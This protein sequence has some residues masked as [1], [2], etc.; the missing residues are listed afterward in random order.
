MSDKSIVTLCSE[1]L[2]WSVSCGSNWSKRISVKGY[3]LGNSPLF[4]F[5][6]VLTCAAMN[7]PDL[8]IGFH[9]LP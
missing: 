7:V 9:D 2:F 1:I 4:Y 5:A 6:L 8:T 3:L